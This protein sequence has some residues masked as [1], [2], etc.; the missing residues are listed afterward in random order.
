M[1]PKHL[2]AAKDRKG[3]NLP[4]GTCVAPIGAREI[5]A[6]VHDQFCALLRQT[7]LGS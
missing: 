1:S 4:D 7:N 2:L 3:P 5:L 6:A